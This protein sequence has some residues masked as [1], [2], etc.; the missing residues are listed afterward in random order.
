MITDS[1]EDKMLMAFV[2]KEKKFNWYKETF[3]KYNVNGIDRFAWRWS[4]WAF[5]C[6]YIYLIYR[7]AYLYALFY[8]ALSI[9]LSFTT[10]PAIAI[11]SIILTISSGGILPYFVYLKYKKDKEKIEKTIEDEDV[12]IETMREIGGTNKAIL[13]IMIAIFVFM[14]FLSITVSAFALLA[15]LAK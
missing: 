12:R 10:S 8:F 14:L 7:K 3:S 4:W 9:A 6:G 1:Y 5:S 13:I 15:E 2:Q 11:F